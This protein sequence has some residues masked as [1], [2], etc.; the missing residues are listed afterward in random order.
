MNKTKVIEVTNSKTTD[1]ICN[2]CNSVVFGGESYCNICG[3][4]LNWDNTVKK[5]I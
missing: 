2:S 3:K 4:K 5:D 1:Y